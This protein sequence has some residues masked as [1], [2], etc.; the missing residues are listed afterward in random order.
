MKAFSEIRHIETDVLIVGAGV[1]GML[2]VVGAKRA[3]IS[4]VIATKGAYASGSSSMARGGHSIAV[5]HSS[6][7]DNPTIFFED[8]VKGSHGI[9]N[10]RLIDLVAEESL[11]RSAELDAWG[12]GLVKDEKGHYDQIEVARLWLKDT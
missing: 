7:D 9:G 4:P 5:G 12:L 10:P 8:I 2:A 1:A 3:G 6:P 11:A